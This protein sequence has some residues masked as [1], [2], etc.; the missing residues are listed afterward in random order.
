MMRSFILG[1]STRLNV[2]IQHLLLQ[3]LFGQRLGELFEPQILASGY[4]HNYE[5]FMKKTSYQMS[6]NRGRTTTAEGSNA[7][8]VRILSFLPFLSW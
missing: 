4:R 1:A 2:L 3:S 8:L 6:I 5:G 7:S